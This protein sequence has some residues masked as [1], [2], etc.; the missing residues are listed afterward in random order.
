MA[1]TTKIV[2]KI[3]PYKYAARIHKRTGKPFRYRR[4]RSFKKSLIAEFGLQCVYCRSP[5]IL[6]WRDSAAV[7]HYLPRKDFPH[8]ETEYSNL[9]LSCSRCN[10]LKGSYWSKDERRRVLNPCDDRMSEHLKF[11]GAEVGGLTS[12]GRF[13]TNLLRLNDDDRT[14]DRDMILGAISAGVSVLLAIKRKKNKTPECQSDVANTIS[15]LSQYT[16]VDE[17]KLRRLLT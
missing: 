10:S 3:T 7:E 17:L 15:F 2:Q 13:H 1:E 9:F 4:Y 11:L 12:S 14:R 6:G 5:L 8:L 16:L